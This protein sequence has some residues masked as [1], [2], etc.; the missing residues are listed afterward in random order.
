M[1]DFL[2]DARD[3]KGA[4][5]ETVALVYTDYETGQEVSKGLEK[6]LKAA[7]FKIVADVPLPAESDN[8]KPQLARIKSMDPDVAVGLVTTDRKSSTEGKRV[9]VRRDMGGWRSIKKKK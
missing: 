5:L 9:S 4:K 3:K 1:A 7:G 2:I 6:R 8:Y